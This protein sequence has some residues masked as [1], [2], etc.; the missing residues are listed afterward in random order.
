MVAL[1]STSKNCS[2]Y[3]SVV[4]LF[5]YYAVIKKLLFY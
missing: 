5:V 4:A 2:V 1:S 3:Y